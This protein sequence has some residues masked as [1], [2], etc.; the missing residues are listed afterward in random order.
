MSSQAGIYEIGV[1]RRILSG[2]DIEEIVQGWASARTQYLYINLLHWSVFVIFFGMFSLSSL[3]YWVCSVY[4]SKACGHTPWLFTLFSPSFLLSSFSL[5]SL[6]SFSLFSSFCSCLFSSFLHF[7]LF[8]LFFSIFKQWR[9]WIGLYHRGS[10]CLLQ[11]VPEVNWYSF[12]LYYCI[13]NH[14]FFIAIHFNFKM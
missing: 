12:M 8:I 1:N 11:N 6:S 13:W 14:I 7:L 10:G 5:F 3:H 9:G 4:H 2:R